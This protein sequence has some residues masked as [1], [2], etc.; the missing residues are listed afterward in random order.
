M[1]FK[2]IFLRASLSTSTHSAAKLFSG[3]MLCAWI[4]LIPVS[5]F[6]GIDYDRLLMLA[7]E[8]YGEPAY[9]TIQ[10]LRSLI[11]GLKTQPELY[12]INEIN[13]FVNQK[14]AH[15]EEDIVIWGQSDYWATPLESLGK[16]AGDC[17]DYS[18]AKY[19]FLKAAGIPTHKL[20]LTYVR[21]QIGGPESKI[22]QAHMVLSYYANANA[23]PLILDNLISDIKPASRRQD[24]R[25][26]FAFNDDGIWV[27][28][29]KSAQGDSSSHLSRWRDLLKRARD[30]GIE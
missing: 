24:L 14:I 9:H 1:L 20:R 17:E 25:P 16:R 15:F 7:R 27:G 2:H 21:A 12:K 8:R 22:F 18:I 29:G 5:G 13:R 3:L 26:I 23:D 30:E 4:W 19:M 11:S 28:R 6:A 10:E